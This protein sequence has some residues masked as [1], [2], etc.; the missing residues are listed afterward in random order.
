MPHWHNLG[1]GILDVPKTGE[2][3]ETDE[4]TA[5]ENNEISGCKRGNAWFDSSKSPVLK[6][7]ADATDMPAREHQP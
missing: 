7:N 5:N 6:C 4:V 3:G 1:S 2:I